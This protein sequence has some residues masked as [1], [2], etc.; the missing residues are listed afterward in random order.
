MSSFGDKLPL[1]LRYPTERIGEQLG[2]AVGALL[3]DEADEAH[4]RGSDLADGFSRFEVGEVIG[5]IPVVYRG[6]GEPLVF[7]DDFDLDDVDEFGNL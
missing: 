3:D 4:V 1:D 5:L 6:K 7:A 2:Q